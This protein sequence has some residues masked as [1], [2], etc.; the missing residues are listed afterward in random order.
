LPRKWEAAIAAL[1]TC[2]TVTA[3]AAAV[4]VNESTLRAWMRDPAFDAAFREARR[5][6]VDQAVTRLQRLCVRAVKTL[7]KAMRSG[8]VNAQVRAAKIV[9]DMAMRGV[10]VDDLAREVERL[11]QQV[12]GGRGREPGSAAQ[13]GGK[14]AGDRPP[15]GPGSDATAGPSEGRPVVDLLRGGADAG[16]VADEAPPLE[17]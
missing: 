3:A 16:P 2:P 5:R 11:R 1:L 17:L 14:G 13:A 4:P 7:A 9:L 15:D 8:D 12:E 6:A 10:E